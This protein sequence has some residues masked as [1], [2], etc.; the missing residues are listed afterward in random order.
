MGA[1]YQNFRETTP[2]LKDRR[3]RLRALRLEMK[4]HALDGF[5]VPR[6]DQF[7]GEYIP[8]SEER[9][10]WLTGFDGS[11][12]LAMVLSERAALFTDGRYRL[13]AAMQADGKSFENREW[14]QDVGFWLSH[15]IPKKGRLGYDPWLHTMEEAKTLRRIL[16]K[17]KASLI[18]MDENLVDKIWTRRPRPPSQMM[19]AHPLRYAGR[20]SEAKR[21]VIS[22]ILKRA[23]EDAALLC[24]P[25]S[26]AWL[27]NIRGKDVPHTPFILCFG[28]LEKS[29]KAHLFLDSS[30][31]SES[32]EEHLG[33]DVEIHPEDRMEDILKSFTKKTLRVA[34]QQT[35]EALRIILEKAEVKLSP[36][37]DPC[38]VPKACKN[39]AEIAGAR[40][41]HLYDGVA[42]AQFL[43]WLSE[44]SSG[45]GPMRIDEM[46]AARKLESFRRQSGL[47]MDI[48][49]DTI[50]GVGPHSAIVHYRVNQKTNRQFKNHDL[51][52]VD[53]GGQYREG[54]TDVTRTIAVG[55]PPEEARE[56]FTRVLKG[57]IGLARAFFPQG[58]TGAQLDVLARQHLW[59]AGLDFDHGTGHG[60]GS[61]LSVHEGPQGISP[62]ASAPLRAGM[63]LSNEPGY[64]KEG[65]WGIRIESLVLVR[66][67]PWKAGRRGMLFF[68]TLTLAPIDPSLILLTLLSREEKEWLNR[69][70]KNVRVK[71]TPH[72]PSKTAL[73]LKDATQP[74]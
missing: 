32:V 52:L 27:F 50:S 74:L 47:L 45:G 34:P 70:H 40:Q 21:K 49:F 29:G 42:L 66:A 7:Q 15:H 55:A 17:K 59:E 30:R 60:V 63:I 54:T 33:A 10:A 2:P 72:L 68:E 57:H 13:Q 39:R 69:Y 43:A 31:V 20:T 22:S 65:A 64:Y 37:P 1:M 36:A 16:E 6:A 11:A 3:Q 53:S 44:A 61:Y 41:A 38:L 62:R 9:L 5:L 4:A 12:G 46:G 73:W 71:L 28:L 35:P 8:A 25:A 19:E 24:D 56:R 58:T 48:S 51:Y 18:P 23:K 67:A 14:P 26:L